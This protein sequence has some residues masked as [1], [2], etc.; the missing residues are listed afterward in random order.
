M[1]FSKR[2]SICLA[3]VPLWG[4]FALGAWHF[5][6]ASPKAPA[7]QVPKI[8]DRTE[9]PEKEDASPLNSRDQAPVPDPRL[10]VPKTTHNETPEKRSEVLDEEAQTGP[11]K[12]PV[13]PPVQPE[14]AEYIVPR[15]TRRKLSPGTTISGLRVEPD[16]TL[17]LPSGDV[18]ITGDIH[19]E[20]TVTR[21]ADSRVILDGNVTITGDAKLSRA[22]VRGGTTRIRNKVNSGN[23][24]NVAKPGES[25]L[26]VEKGATLIIEKDGA[27]A[28]TTAYGYQIA[29]TLII[30]G[31]T[32][33]CTFGNGTGK[34]HEDSWLAGSELIINSGRFVGNGDHDFTGASITIHD[35]S[36]EIND[37]IWGTGDSFVMYGGLMRNT[38]GGGMFSINGNF[39]MTGGTVQVH[40]SGHRSL[41]VTSNASVYCTGGEVQ[42]LGSA[43]GGGTGGIALHG[44][45]TFNKAVFRTSSHVAEGSSKEISLVIGELLIDRNMRFDAKGY[46]VNAGFFPGDNQ[47]EFLP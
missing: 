40:Q 11:V 24:E 34:E 5:F 10:E 6:A 43:A 19:I 38:K 9:L 44:S 22:I 33:Q 18:T 2:T 30:D 23:G 41:R 21:P 7:T 12:S 25:N 16:S 15:E 20:G 47:G 4:L 1:R 29:G 14:T 31:G 28:A 13:K 3:L 46:N 42:I 8:A 36:L 35:G 32:F 26:Y 27:W 39:N 45:A 17:E 37:D